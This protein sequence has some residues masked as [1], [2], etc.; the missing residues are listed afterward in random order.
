M[1]KLLSYL[2]QSDY[3]F[4]TLQPDLPG[5]REYPGENMAPPHLPV[6][7]QLASSLWYIPYP[8]S[9]R[10]QIYRRSFQVCRQCRENSDECRGYQC[11]KEKVYTKRD[12]QIDFIPKIKNTSKSDIFMY[13]ACSRLTRAC[14]AYVPP[15]KMAWQSIIILLHL[16]YFPSVTFN[17]NCSRKVRLLYTISTRQLTL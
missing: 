3:M 6:C 2:D 5:W 11:T 13:C 1:E 7:T 16:K 15:R 10:L 4:C 8:V 12:K 17:K 14:S 9:C